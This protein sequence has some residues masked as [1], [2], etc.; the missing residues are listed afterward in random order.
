MQLETSRRRDNAKQAAYPMKQADAAET[1]KRRKQLY[2]TGRQAARLHQR[3]RWPHG[4]TRPAVHSLMRDMKKV[5]PDL[6]EVRVKIIPI[7]SRCG[8]RIPH[9]CR[10]G[11]RMPRFRLNDDEFKRLPPSF[12]SAALTDT[13]PSKK[14]GDPVKG[15]E[16]FETRGCMGCHSLDEANPRVF[17]ANLSRVGEKDNYD[18]LVRWIHNPRERTR[19]YCPFEKNDL[20]QKITKHGLPFVFDLDH[21]QV[22]E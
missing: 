18:Y 20:R 8:C 10:P 13:C 1:T 11:T 17:A 15:K 4:A 14:P 9:A 5:G 12:G 22:P 3:H 19:P 7:G 21:S 2:Y 16:I 6:K